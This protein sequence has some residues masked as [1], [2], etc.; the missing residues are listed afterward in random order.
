MRECCIMDHIAEG[1]EKL[2]GKANSNHL[3]QLKV[4]LCL[5]FSYRMIRSGFNKRYDAV[6]M[7]CEYYH[8]KDE[9]ANVS[10]SQS[11]LLVQKRRLV[12]LLI[13]GELSVPNIL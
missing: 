10:L 9:E 7:S 13:V 6:Q 4:E 1:R 11:Y 3:D 12:T 5:A 8:E 2:K